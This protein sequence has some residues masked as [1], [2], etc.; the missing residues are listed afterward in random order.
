[1]W[2]NVFTLVVSA[3]SFS[4]GV[5]RQLGFRPDQSKWWLG[6]FLSFFFL[7]VV[8]LEFEVWALH[9]LGGHST[10]RAMPLALFCTGFGYR[11]SLYGQVGL[12]C[13]PPILSFLPA[14]RWQVPATSPSCFLLRWNLAN[15]FYPGWPR[16][17]I[18]L[19]SASHIAW[20]DRK[21][22]PPLRPA[23]VWDG[24][25]KSSWS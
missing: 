25:L 4:T 7:V 5:L 18:L 24:V 15:F 8:V 2:E 10:A 1:M 19:I 12:D 20:D 21:V 14:L 17:K 9:L 16:T 6:F 11:V 23:I 3:D 22:P 13:D